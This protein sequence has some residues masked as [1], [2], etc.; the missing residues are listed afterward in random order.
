MGGR[1]CV[2]EDRAALPHEENSR[3][4]RAE[5][6]RD[7]LGRRREPAFFE[8]CGNRL[9]GMSGKRGRLFPRDRQPEIDRIALCEPGGFPDPLKS[10]AS[11]SAWNVS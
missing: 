8:V 9:F 5:G 6:Y 7:N 4:R 11:A 1:G 10:S 3:P 2:A